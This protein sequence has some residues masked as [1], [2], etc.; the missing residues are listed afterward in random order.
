MESLSHLVAALQDYTALG[1]AALA[2]CT[3][4]ITMVLNWRV[5]KLLGN[6]LAHKMDRHTDLLTEIRDILR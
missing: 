3:L 4:I 1:V 5:V 6:H 2:L